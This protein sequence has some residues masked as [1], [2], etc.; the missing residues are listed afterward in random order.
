MGGGHWVVWVKPLGGHIAMYG[1]NRVAWVSHLVVIV[2]GGGNRVVRVVPPCDHCHEWRKPECPCQTTGW[3]LLW[4]KETGLSESNHL[5]IIVM[6]GGNRF[7][8]VRVRLVA[9]ESP[10]AAHIISY[11]LHTFDWGCTP[12]SMLFHVHNNSQHYFGRKP[13]VFRGNPRPSPGSYQTIPGTVRGEASMKWTWTHCDPIDEKLLGHFTQM[14]R[15]TNSATESTPPPPSL[16]VG[17]SITICKTSSLHKPA[18]RFV[19]EFIL[20]LLILLYL[21]SGKISKACYGPRNYNGTNNFLEC[22]EGTEIY[23][24]EINYLLFCQMDCPYKIPTPGE[25]Y[26]RMWTETEANVRLELQRICSNKRECALFT[27]GW[28][29]T[30]GNKSRLPDDC[31]TPVNHVREILYT[32]NSSGKYFKCFLLCRQQAGY[33]RVSHPVAL[34]KLYWAWRKIPQ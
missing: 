13:A 4:L 7:V 27:G 21:S 20:L 22:D 1:G 34:V 33:C 25:D 31:R 3:S 16:P 8:Q 24:M 26:A 19:L 32:C 10:G 2:M 23:I 12:Y 30:P 28:L 14:D 6:G 17:S 18:P 5:V 9:W 11:G 15:L 29:E